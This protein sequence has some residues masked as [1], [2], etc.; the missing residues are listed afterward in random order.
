MDNFYISYLCVQTSLLIRESEIKNFK[1]VLN[2]GLLMLFANYWYVVLVKA[3]FVKSWANTKTTH[4][5][6][7]P[8]LQEDTSKLA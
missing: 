4:G 6:Q 8:S 2:A 5:F 3:F 1:N 7:I